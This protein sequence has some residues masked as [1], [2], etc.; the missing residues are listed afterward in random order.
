MQLDTGYCYEEWLSRF[1]LH[2][3]RTISMMARYEHLHVF[4]CIHDLGM[5]VHFL[6][7]CVHH[8]ALY[9]SALP[10]IRDKTQTV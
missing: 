4:L 8:I 6:M 7:L 2:L 3:G 10:T 1:S 5:R 9:D